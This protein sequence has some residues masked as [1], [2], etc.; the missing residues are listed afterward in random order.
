MVRRFL[1]FCVG[2]VLT[3]SSAAPAATVT[4]QPGDDLQSDINR[5]GAG[6]TV[7]FATGT[8]N[9]GPVA[10]HTGQTLIGAPNFGSHVNF[11]CSGQTLYGMAVDA[12]ASNITLT[13]I[14]L[15]SSN[16]LICLRDGTRYQN[17]HITGNQLQF[18][19]G[20]LA[21]GTLVFGIFGSI[22]CDDLQ[23]CFNYFHDSPNSVRNWNCGA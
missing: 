15:H 3:L 1:L 11:S 9:S 8:F 5:A 19:G 17:I 2:A 7:I 13:G 10:V 23:I 6:G 18:G 12:N 16:G 21:D 4:A 14:D 20:S 22:G